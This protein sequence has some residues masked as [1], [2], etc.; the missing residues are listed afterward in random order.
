VDLQDIRVVAV[1]DY[2][3]GLVDPLVCVR[4]VLDRL[5]EVQPRPCYRVFWVRSCAFRQTLN[6]LKAAAA[7]RAPTVSAPT[8]NKPED[9][10]DD[11]A[12]DQPYNQAHG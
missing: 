10:T 8:E 3:D 5:C 9:Y 7:S 2:L 4:L 12:D 1:V 6:A 11:G